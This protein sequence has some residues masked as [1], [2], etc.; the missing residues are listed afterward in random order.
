MTAAVGSA[1]N[2][3]A[4]G[5]DDCCDGTYGEGTVSVAKG[6][7]FMLKT[8]VSSTFTVTAEATAAPSETVGAALFNGRFD[9]IHVDI[10]GGAGDADVGVHSPGEDEIGADCDD[11]IDNSNDAND[12]DGS[13]NGD[14][15]DLNR[16]D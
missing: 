3:A 6:G 8:D 7:A 9:E 12:D 13:E 4:G 16:S 5:V 11:R 1:L 10:I 2:D 15:D 14:D